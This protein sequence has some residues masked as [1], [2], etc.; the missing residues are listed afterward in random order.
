M[1]VNGDDDVIRFATK[2]TRSKRSRLF[3]VSRP[4]KV[5]QLS[6]SMARNCDQTRSSA[7][8]MWRE[9]FESETFVSKKRTARRSIISHF[10]FFYPRPRILFVC[11]ETTRFGR[12]IEELISI[13]RL[14]AILIDCELLRCPLSRLSNDLFRFLKKVFRFIGAARSN[15]NKQ[16]ISTLFG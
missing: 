1:G 4:Q 5:C 11:F 14:C 16:T 10:F 3:K 6:S 7:F 2:S 12:E 15:L 13:R 8:H 9:L